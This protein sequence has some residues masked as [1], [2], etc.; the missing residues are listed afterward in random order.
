MRIEPTGAKNYEA[1]VTK[2]I[3][4]KQVSFAEK[5][6]RLIAEY[7]WNP[8]SVRIES[9]N[10]STRARA[11]RQ[12]A[13]IKDYTDYSKLDRQ[14]VRDLLSE[15]STERE[16]LHFCLIYNPSRLEEAK[17]LA[18]EQCA[19]LKGMFDVICNHNPGLLNTMV[20][21]VRAGKNLSSLKI[22]ELFLARVI[23]HIPLDY[24]DANEGIKEMCQKLGRGEAVASLQTLYPDEPSVRQK[25]FDHCLRIFENK[26]QVI[27]DLLRA[28]QWTGTQDISDEKWWEI[29]THP[30]RNLDELKRTYR[31]SPKSKDALKMVVQKAHRKL[32]V[33]IADAKRTTSSGGHSRLWD[34][35]TQADAAK[36]EIMALLK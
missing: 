10:L 1:D 6:K 19:H 8:G 5:V 2:A 13:S 32:G 3:A 31:L 22:D 26:G 9:E 11:L 29:L 17:I 18:P 12:I 36:A 27:K 23:S 35:D 34:L 25:I 14:A 15:V 20:G 28:D 33:D 4:S 24:L 7:I 16:L 30:D 21:A